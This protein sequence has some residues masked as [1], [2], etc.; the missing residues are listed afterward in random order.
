[1]ASVYG[2]FIWP[3]NTAPRY[4]MG[5]SITTALM[6]VSG[7]VALGLKLKFGDKGV[8]SKKTHPRM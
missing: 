5:F 8:V 7:L 3:A 6:G 1:M 4:T 2:S